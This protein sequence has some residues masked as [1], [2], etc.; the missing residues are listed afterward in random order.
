[1]M[2]LPTSA[3]VHGA[4]LAAKTHGLPYDELDTTDI[5]SRFPGFRPCPDEVGIYEPIAGY[6]QVEAALDALLSSAREAGAV[7]HFNCTV[8]SLRSLPSHTV[9]TTDRESIEARQVVLTVGAWLQ[10][11][12]PTLPLDVERQVPVWFK[13]R[14]A[15][16]LTS[17]PIYIRE[18]PETGIQVYGFPYLNGQGIKAG[19]HHGGTVSS[20]SDIDRHV[21]QQDIDQLASALDFVPPIHPVEVQ[22]ARV[23][24][25][26]NTPDGHFVI[27]RNPDWPTVVVAGGFPGH[28]F[29]FGPALGQLLVDVA[30]HGR[31]APYL[32]NPQR[33]RHGSL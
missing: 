10:E 3:V 15:T 21:H 23:C 1:M 16:P 31:Q 22:D 7:A 26:T 2:G 28:G 25:Y 12:W 24:L 4:R 33:G 29:K 20:V 32:F 14:H 17:L 19:I 5:V 11:W 8:Q 13:A 9:I 18:Q 27:G 30:L 6:L